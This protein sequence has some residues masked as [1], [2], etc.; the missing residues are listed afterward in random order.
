MIADIVSVR[1][2]Y[3]VGA[4]HVMP[5]FASVGAGVHFAGI[6]IDAA[7]LIGASP[8]ANTLAVSLGYSF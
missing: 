7:Y 3:N 6:K 2:G 1:A 5:S 4:K 8:I